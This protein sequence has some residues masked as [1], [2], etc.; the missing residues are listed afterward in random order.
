MAINLPLGIDSF[1]R[2]RTEKCYY[3]DKT[4]LIKKLLDKSYTVNLITRPRR[5]GKTLT[6][7]MLADFFDIQKDS[8]S[9]FAGL[10]ISRH[11]ELCDQ[12]MNQW[13]VLFITFKSVEG[14]SFESAYEM[15]EV[16]ISDLY[17]EHLYLGTSSS[18]NEADQEY[19]QRFIA[20]KGSQ[21]ELKNSLYILMRMMHS[22]FGKPVILLIDEYDVPLAKAND[23]GYYEQILDVM[24]SMLGKVLKTN[25]FLKISVV[26]GCLK[27]AK[28]SIFT[29]T[30]HFVSDTVTSNRFDAFFGFTEQE[31]YQLLEDTGFTDHVKIIKE[32][33]DGYRFGST[34]IYC[35]WDVL[36]YI[37]ALQDDPTHDP[38]TYWA[39]TSG[40]S[41]VRSFIKKANKSTQHEIEQLISGDGVAKK[42]SQELTYNELD[43][44]I[45]NMW[46][47][48]FSTGYLTQRGKTKSG[49]LK[50]VIPNREVQEIFSTQIL[51]WFEETVREKPAKLMAFCDALERGDADSVQQQFNSYLLSTIS[52]R[53]TAVRKELKE[54]FYHGVLHGMLIG[55]DD[56]VVRSNEESGISYCDILVE[57]PGK[58]IGLAIEIKYAEDDLL[59][60]GCK[61][62]LNQIKNKQYAAKLQSDGMNKIYIYGIACYKKHCKAVCEEF[63]G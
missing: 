19:F 54:N 42:I 56:W 16:L 20:K 2:L 52:I 44:S 34:D 6:M 9:R 25:D 39:N 4:E 41:I 50:L 37:G 8:S 1:E 27:I 46:S 47:V 53:D 40:N 28:E 51:K 38:E 55:N 24:R 12:W 30:N 23:Y 43:K 22:H 59:D 36:N 32:W 33:Y 63:C 5:F 14:L 7:R 60:A 48:L 21:A 35:P 13:P 31:V 45:D 17:I 18:V 58:S 26:T 61:D 11:N 15:L 49:A 57:I 10:K 3:I 62:A 29:G